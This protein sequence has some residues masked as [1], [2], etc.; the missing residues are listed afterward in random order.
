MLKAKAE[1]V[2]HQLQTKVQDLEDQLESVHCVAA[3]ANS[4]APITDEDHLL[5]APCATR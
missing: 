4:P 3:P 2:M 5:S 1:F